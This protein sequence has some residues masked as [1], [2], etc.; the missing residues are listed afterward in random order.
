M[1]RFGIGFFNTAFSGDL[2]KSLNQIYGLDIADERGIEA[3]YNLAVTPWF[4]VA[5]DLQ[6][7]RPG[8]RSF[9]DAFFAGLSAQ[10]KL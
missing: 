2:T 3:F 4:R 5:L 8:V 7:I 6:F 10:I 9:D 1:D